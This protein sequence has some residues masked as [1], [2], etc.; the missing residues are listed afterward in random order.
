[1]DSRA[2]TTHMG[3]KKNCRAAYTVQKNKQLHPFIALILTL[4]RNRRLSAVII[5]MKI[6]ILYIC[7]GKYHLFWKDFYSSAC[8]FLFTEHEKHFFIFSDASPLLFE[9]DD[10]TVIYQKKLGWPYDTLKRFHMFLTVESTLKKYDYIF[11]FNANCVFQCPVDS[12]ILPTTNDGLLVVQHP[13]FFSKKPNSFTYDRNPKS[14]AY[15]PYGKG[16]CYVAGGV[17]GGVA[18][19][20]IDLAYDLAWAIDKDAMHGV[21]ALWHDESHL[22]KYILNR[23]YKLLSPAYCYPEGLNLPFENIITIRKK[24]NFGGHDFLRGIGDEF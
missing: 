16:A 3:A 1:M 15:I 18:E 9:H 12:K 20:Y 4:C 8:K 21:I 2:L 11:F 14:L 23:Q 17:N 6:A 22:N 10:V 13:G 5:D 24:E 7:T 19:K